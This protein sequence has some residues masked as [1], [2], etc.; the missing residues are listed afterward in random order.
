[1]HDPPRPQPDR[2]RP[3]WCDHLP[4][5]GGSPVAAEAER[6]WPPVV[7]TAGRGLAGPRLRRLAG[8]TSGAPGRFPGE[9]RR[10]RRGACPCRETGARPPAHLCPRTE[11]RAGEVRFRR[12]LPWWTASTCRSPRRWCR[13]SSPARRARPSFR[14]WAWGR[15]WWGEGRAGGLGPYARRA[16]HRPGSIPAGAGME[17]GPAI[18]A[19]PV[20][21]GP[22]TRV[23]GVEACPVRVVRY[24]VPPSRT[25][26][27]VVPVR[28]ASSVAA[29]R[30]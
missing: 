22:G 6:T 30:A 9:R 20:L 24:G 25:S 17:P 23:A 26:R 1:M 16:R 15:G 11:H 29:S 3:Q 12:S 13:G 14:R 2:V 10:R 27:G 8:R 21:P 5:A 19:E 4:A 28:A 7:R 18:G